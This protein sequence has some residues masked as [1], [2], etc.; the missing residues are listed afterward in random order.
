LAFSLGANYDIALARG[1]QGN[2]NAGSG[3]ALTLDF[4]KSAG[5]SS[6]TW[7]ERVAARGLNRRPRLCRLV[8]IVTG[9][10]IATFQTGK[11]PD[12]IGWAS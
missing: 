4:K 12:G 5:W 1:K 10:Q 9:K 2:P 8:D 3:P 6:R 11:K 7:F